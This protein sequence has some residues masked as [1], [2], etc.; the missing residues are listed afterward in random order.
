MYIIIFLIKKLSH[1]SIVSVH[2]LKLNFLLFYVQSTFDVLCFILLLIFPSEFSN[3]KSCIREL[4][5]EEC[6]TKKGSRTFHMDVLFDGY[7]PFCMNRIYQPPTT[8][9][10]P[11]R[12]HEQTTKQPTE[13]RT[14]TP[15]RNTLATSGLSY[16]KLDLNIYLQILLALLSAG[17]V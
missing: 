15:R 9:T 13:E 17:Y 16:N 14:K 1:D 10:T 6:P 12:E 7:N 5:N 11:L 3:A 4:L 8:V 2:H